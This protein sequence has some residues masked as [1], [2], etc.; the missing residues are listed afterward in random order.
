MEQIISYVADA[1]GPATMLLVCALACAISGFAW[2]AVE[3]Q[4]STIAFGVMYGF[5]SGTYISLVLTTIATWLCSRPDM[6][7]LYIGMMTI[8]CAL[9]FLVGSPVGG[10]LVGN[11]WLAVQLFT[12]STLSISTMAIFALRIMLGGWHPQKC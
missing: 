8:P 12:G 11:G 2:I 7:G 3:S 10:A 1:T 6:L 5:F 9:G 4:A